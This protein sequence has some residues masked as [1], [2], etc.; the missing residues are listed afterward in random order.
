MF[1]V[2]VGF[3]IFI[4][5]LSFV[6]AFFLGEA[7]KDLV[8]FVV[9]YS[10]SDE[11]R[12]VTV[13]FCCVT[14]LVLLVVSKHE[15]TWSSLSTDDKSSRFEEH[16]GQRMDDGDDGMKSNDM[17]CFRVADLEDLEDVDGAE[18]GADVDVVVV[19]V[20]V[21]VCFLLDVDVVDA[22]DAVDAFVDRLSF[23]MVA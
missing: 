15:L 6:L 22:V 20:V 8:G 17:G 1:T 5:L 4:G 13:D 21:V 23:F 3:A 18:S 19:V 14:L 10:S 9:E 7:V 2:S 16:I 12:E 11:N